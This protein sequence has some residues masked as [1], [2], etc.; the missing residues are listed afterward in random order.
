LER[1]THGVDK[2]LAIKDGGCLGGFKRFQEGMVCGG[3]VVD[4]E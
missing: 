4:W 3:F 2:D 1:L